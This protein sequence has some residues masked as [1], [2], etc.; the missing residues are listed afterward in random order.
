M[1]YQA[2]PQLG[3]TKRTSEYIMRDIVHD[4]SKDCC[5]N[6]NTN[7][8][9]NTNTNIKHKYQIQKCFTKRRAEYIMRDIVLDA[10]NGPRLRGHLFFIMIHTAT[11]RYLLPAHATN[12]Q[13]PRN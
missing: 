13:C 2:A 3:R 11:H 12:V 4:V 10:R 1:I 6:T 5:K 8:D 9:T 7:K